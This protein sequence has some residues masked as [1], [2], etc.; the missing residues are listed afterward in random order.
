MHAK[1]LTQSIDTRPVA[2][3]AGYGQPPDRRRLGRR[4]RGVVPMIAEAYVRCV[5]RAGR[6][7][8]P[9]ERER[10]C[11]SHHPTQTVAVHERTVQELDEE[12]RGSAGRD[13][14]AAAG[15]AHP[16]R[17]GFGGDAIEG[18]P[19]NAKADGVRARQGKDRRGATRPGVVRG[20][21]HR[22]QQD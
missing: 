11:Q 16:R 13:A 8:H 5:R 14:H 3:A 9:T 17:E 4:R 22:G 21:C 2:F 7:Y 18:E 15:T 6:Y 19:A 12:T 20:A 1:Q 10:A